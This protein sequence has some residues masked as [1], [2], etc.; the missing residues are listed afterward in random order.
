[1]D[2]P[3]PVDLLYDGCSLVGV[4]VALWVLSLI[5]GKTWPV[6]FI[7]SCWPP[8]QSILIY[9]R[10]PDE[11]ACMRQ[12]ATFCLIFVWGWRLTHNFIYRGGI[13]HEDWRYTDM[14]E[15]FGR[16]FW[17]A[18]LFTVFLGQTIFMFGPCLSLYA[19]I[20]S[21]LPLRAVDAVA[22]ATCSL[23]ILLETVSD[24]QMD[25]F[26]QAKREKR[27]DKQVIDSGL[28]LWSRHPN[29]C[30]EVLWWW[31]LWLFGI[32]V[33]PAWVV[34]GPLL[35][36]FLFLG[37]SIKLIEDR[38]L[39]N[40]GDAFREYRKVVPSAIVLLPPPLNRQLGRWLYGPPAQKSVNRVKM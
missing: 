28:W 20:L 33:A 34:A 11:G 17:W 29:Y 39:K 9:V 15:Q 38:Q 2:F 3:P 7:W 22:I 27:C 23:A 12:L 26:M 10:H 8:V 5:L 18:S 1:M 37:V 4:N 30:G 32:G 35:I 19:A 14:R 36:T 40:K 13:G 21:N 25:H 24:M 6:D 31:G 16:H